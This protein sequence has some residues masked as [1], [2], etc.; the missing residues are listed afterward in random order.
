MRTWHLRQSAGPVSIVGTIRESLLVCLVC[1]T[2]K[3][4]AT[5]IHQKSAIP[6][7]ALASHLDAISLACQAS[8]KR[9]AGETVSAER[10]RI[11]YFVTSGNGKVEPGKRA[12]A[13]SKMGCSKMARIW[14]QIRNQP[15]LD[16]ST[17]NMAPASHDA[18][19]A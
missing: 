12:I 6:R 2:D 11:P 16:E 18:N 3:I 8:L 7:E 1:C 13:W 14:I 19:S 10:G 9:G 5:A 15:F 17:R 4:R